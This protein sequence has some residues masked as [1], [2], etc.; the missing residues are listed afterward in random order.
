[1]KIRF[2]AVAAFGLMTGSAGSAMAQATWTY[3]SP[4]GDS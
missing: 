3:P 4:L 2:A 1:M